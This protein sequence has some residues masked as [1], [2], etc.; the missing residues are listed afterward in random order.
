MPINKS[1]KLQTLNDAMGLQT[2]LNNYYSEYEKLP[3]FGMGGDE[4]QTDGVVG[5]KLLTI[6]LG[7]E[8]VSDDMQNK[9]QITFLNAKV[10]KNRAKGGLIYSN[11]GSA[12][13]PEG[14]YDAWG[15]PFRL[16]FDLDNDQEIADPLE[17]GNIIRNKQV[18]VY[19]DGEDKKPQSE[20]DIKTW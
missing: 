13:L 6:L 2:A 8:E 16:K 18:I 12:T 11:G 7:K 5:S 1:K 15:R 10:N 3:E 9:K 4:A 14:L 20:D 19:S 17:E